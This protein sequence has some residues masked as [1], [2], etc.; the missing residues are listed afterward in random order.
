MPILYLLAGPNGSGKS[1]YVTRLLQPVT[2]LP[3][4][5]ADDIAAERWPQ[6]QAEHAY[7]AS[8]AAAGERAELLAAGASFVTETVFSHSSKLELV[9]EAL[10]RGYL[11]HLHVMLVPVRVSVNRVAERVRH[12]GHDVPEQKIR[13]R[14]ARLWDLVVQARASADRTEFFDNSSAGHPF[15]RV[16]AYERGLL[17]GEADW[18]A[19][20]PTV[21]AVPRPRL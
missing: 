20:A 15:R 8:H 9:N 4:V 7:D 10:V 6:A 16:A 11:V 13:D 21:L 3:F 17:L 2:H 18:P 19:W 12:G 1:T 5:N 14:Y